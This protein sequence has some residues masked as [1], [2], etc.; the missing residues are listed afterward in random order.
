ME[1]GRRRALGPVQGDHRQQV[2]AKQP[3]ARSFHRGPGRELHQRSRRRDLPAERRQS[4]Y[5]AYGTSFDPSLETLA[6]TTGQENL[7]PEKKVLRG[8]QQMGRAAGQ[9]ALTAA[10]FQVEKTNA[11]SQISTG[12]YTLRG[13][14]RPRRRA[15]RRPAHVALAGDRRLHVPRREDHQGVDAGRD[16]RQGARQHAAPRRVAMDH[17]QLTPEWE[18]GGGIT[19]TS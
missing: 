8:R 6:L 14:A 12:V 16:A 9:P 17:L 1:A 13:N 19:Y 7:P 5:V 10:L 4:Y 3:A 11:R 15:A 18:V 2:N